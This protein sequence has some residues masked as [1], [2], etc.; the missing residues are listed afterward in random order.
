M[1]LNHKMT[2]TN[3]HWSVPRPTAVTFGAILDGPTAIPTADIVVE[4]TSRNVVSMVAVSIDGLGHD[5]GL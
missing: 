5:V 1:W 3:D 4:L 2:D